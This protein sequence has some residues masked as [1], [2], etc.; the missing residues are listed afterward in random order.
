MMD[1]S[2]YRR[3]LGTSPPMPDWLWSAIFMVTLFLTGLAVGL[4]LCLYA[5]RPLPT[6]STAVS[7]QQQLN[8]LEQRVRA[9]EHR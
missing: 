4:T 5:S 3:F 9:L 1:D 8:S 2:W 7:F 6:S